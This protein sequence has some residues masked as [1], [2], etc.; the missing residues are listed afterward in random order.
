MS[1]ATTAKA[2]EIVLIEDLREH[3][4]TLT[5]ILELEGH[6]VC[7]ASNGQDGFTLIIDKKPLVAFIDLGLPQLDGYQIAQ[8]VRQAGMNTY[9][10]ALTGYGDDK[11]KMQCL[12]AGFDRHIHKP[13]RIEDLREVMERALLRAQGLREG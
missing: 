6:S 8:R 2:C 12:D 7:S 13:L 9:L 1:R 5:I 3:A 10:V 11:V 4:D